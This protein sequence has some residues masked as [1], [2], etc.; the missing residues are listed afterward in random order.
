MKK[1]KKEYRTDMLLK[2]GL[3][4][5]SVVLRGTEDRMELS[6]QKNEITWKEDDEILGL[7]K[8]EMRKFL[9]SRWPISELKKRYISFLF[10]FIFIV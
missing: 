7:Q 4:S 3:R 8:S 10:Y 5:L 1:A 6:G 2:R 9:Q